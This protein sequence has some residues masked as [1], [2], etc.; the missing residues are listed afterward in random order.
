[1]R[2]RSEAA[3]RHDQFTNPMTYWLIL[4]V[5]AGADLEPATPIDRA[6]VL[7]GKVLVLPPTGI[8]GR[9]PVPRDPVMAAMASGRWQ[10]PTAGV[11]V[12][13]VNGDLTAWGVAHGTPKGT[14]TPPTTRGSYVWWPI[15]VDTG[16]TVVIEA[17]GHSLVY[18]NG[19]PRYGDPYG[20]GYTRTPIRLIPGR[21]ELLFLC[22]RNLSARLVNPVSGLEIHTGDATLP[23][24]LTRSRAPANAAIVV[25]N[26]TTAEITGATITATVGTAPPL[27]TELPALPAL[28]A[29]KV[30]FKVACPPATVPGSQE[31]ALAVHL[32]AD[33][34]PAHTATI[35]I[36]I[37]EPG[38]QQRR[39]FV[40]AVDGSVQYYAV[41]PAAPLSAHD[42]LPGLILSTHGAG[43]EAWNQAGSYV[44]KTWTHIVAPTNRRPY[45]FDWEDWGRMDALET[46]ADASK[47]FKHDPQRVFSSGHSMGGHGA[48][49]LAAT[50]PDRFA[51]VGP[52]AGWMS[53]WSYGGG[54]YAD[55]STA[56][57]RLLERTTTPSRTRLLSRN[58][59]QLG[60]YILHGDADDNVPVAQARQ[61]REHLAAFHEDMHYHEQPGAGH[62]WDEPE[63]PG[64]ECLDWAPMF[65]LFSRR[66]IPRSNELRDIEFVTAN[67][68]ISSTCHWLTIHGQKIA[69]A[70][71]R[72]T[73]RFDPAS[74]RL[75]GTTDNVAR[76]AFDVTPFAPGP[77]MTFEIDG[78]TLT[79]PWPGAAQ[80][81][82]ERRQHEWTFSAPPAP[83]LKGP[84]R[85]GPFKDVFRNRFILVYGT[86][87]SEEEIAWARA[88]ARFDADAFLYR[89]NASVEVMSDVQF[90]GAP[91]AQ[92]NVILYGNAQTN[93]A[94]AVVL[95]DDDIAL[96][97]GS[98]RLGERTLYGSDLGCIMIRPRMGSHRAAVG[99]VG[100][101]GLAGMRI[102]DRLPYFVSGIAYPD[103]TVFDGTTPT[104]GAAGIVAT[105][106]F[107]A[108]WSVARGEFVFRDP[109]PDAA[110][111]D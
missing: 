2:A 35:T 57:G 70:P 28:S 27:K 34:D 81:W 4:I 1:M 41:V 39:T 38:A 5:I 21:N 66:R 32:S 75:W 30:P 95:T 18:V 40:S 6:A 85:N 101:T 51:A 89:A 59:R 37:R 110:E 109:T 106:F 90:R 79:C 43:V 65:D 104:R 13:A 52:S 11:E 53:F 54:H 42:P 61:M 84:Q 99:V 71:S 92:R 62:W 78:H 49:Q 48:W 8:S 76:M 111:P 96:T 97:R 44:A 7:P 33:Q 20:L 23:D 94:W 63:E 91:T 100:G 31:L 102:T 15:D 36:H 87:G 29:R 56:I 64:A 98:I 9:I 55:D 67:P 60:V 14:L 3:L 25:L 105:G 19:Q 107:G 73:L 58:L 26:N 47:H 24:L 88:K 74:R 50:F 16:R 80:V 72:A 17:S 108:D 46:L 68:G 22:S 103:V 86:R 82:L 77:E 12:Q 83:G 69:L 10:A 45:G 93:S